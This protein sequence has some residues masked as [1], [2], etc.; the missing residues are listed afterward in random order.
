MK[1]SKFT[2]TQFDGWPI[3]KKPKETT[4]YD[5]LVNGAHTAIEN[6]LQFIHQLFTEAAINHFGLLLHWYSGG[7]E[8]ENIKLKG[9]KKIRI[10]EQ[11]ADHLLHLDEDYILDVIR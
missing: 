9:R 8:T 6:W 5:N 10:H 3:R 7:V 11:T 4:K 1:K 2:E